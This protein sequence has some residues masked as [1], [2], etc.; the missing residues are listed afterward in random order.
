MLYKV[1]MLF[2]LYSLPVITEIIDGYIFTSIHNKITKGALG[3]YLT[4]LYERVTL[5]PTVLL[6]LTNLFLR[7]NHTKESRLFY[8]WKLQKLI[9]TLS[10]SVITQRYNHID[11]L[12][13]IIGHYGQSNYTN[14]LIDPI[15]KK[16]I[17][18]PLIINL[19]ISALLCIFS[20]S[21]ILSLFVFCW[22]DFLI[23]N[24]SNFYFFSLPLSSLLFFYSLFKFIQ[25]EFS[26][27]THRHLFLL[28]SNFSFLLWSQ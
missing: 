24:H 21:N 5:H 23:F 13:I 6:Y 9:C 17:S 10:Q 22:T 15:T 8:I 4:F 3:N 19:F 20:I 12:L 25:I 1:V 28:L 18:L 2:T 16:L 27:Y 14:P 26:V 7:Y 11:I